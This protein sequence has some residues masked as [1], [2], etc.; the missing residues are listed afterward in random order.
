MGGG[1]EYIQMS[2]ALLLGNIIP[3]SKS[4]NQVGKKKKDSFA[5]SHPALEIFPK[6][7][8][9]KLRLVFVQVRCV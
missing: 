7:W 6:Y 5:Y 4:P 1:G 2:T 3:E 8:Q 9:P